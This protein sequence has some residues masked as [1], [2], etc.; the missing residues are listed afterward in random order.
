MAGIIK[1]YLGVVLVIANDYETCNTKD[2][3]IGTRNDFI[4]YSE[5]FEQLEF[6]V[7]PGQNKAAPDIIKLVSQLEKEAEDLSISGTLK[8][9]AFV[10]CGHGDNGFIFGQ[11]GE[12]LNLKDV[13]DAFRKNPHILRFSQLFFI[14]ACRGGMEDKGIKYVPRG[15]EFK[16]ETLIPSNQKSYVAYSTVP[17]FKAFEV[18]DR[19]LFSAFLN[20]ELCDPSNVNESLDN[21]IVKVSSKMEDHCRHCR[22]P[23]QTPERVTRL[24]HPA[25][26]LQEAEQLKSAISGRSGY[27]FAGTRSSECI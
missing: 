9:T 22:M 8:Y 14:D 19:G 10:F 21:I 11:D 2:T 12:S 23:F 4:A 17:N 13:F 27:T 7:I 6:K 3:L 16:I 20:I 18:E 1:D 25:N 15:G 26:L 24:S 5:T